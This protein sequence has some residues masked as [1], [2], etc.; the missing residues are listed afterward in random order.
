MASSNTVSGACN[1]GKITVK[2]SESSFPSSVSLCHCLNCR[3]SGGSLFA[4]NIIVPSKDIEVQGLPKIHVDTAN[5]GNHANRHFCGDCGSPIMTIVAE[6][7]ETAFLKGGLF[8]KFGY[9]LPAPGREQF[10]RRAEKWEKPREG[11]TLIE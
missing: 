3:A 7:P 2:L 10:W 9:G 1:C 5:S 4:V 8:A 11:V 6:K